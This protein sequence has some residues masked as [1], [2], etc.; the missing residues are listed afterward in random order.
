MKYMTKSQIYSIKIAVLLLFS[1]F[2]ISCGRI[3]STNAE[4]KESESLTSSAMTEYRAADIIKMIKKGKPIQLMN[5]MIWDDLDFT[6]CGEPRIT[7]GIAV[8][9]DVEVPIYFNHCLFMGNVL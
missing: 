7:S 1:F 2:N 4:A 9:V 3:G 6:Q 8:E 5:C